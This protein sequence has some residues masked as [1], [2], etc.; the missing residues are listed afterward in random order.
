MNRKAL[1]WLLP[2]AMAALASP[3]AAETRYKLPPREVVDILD[4]PATPQIELSP[5]RDRALLVWFESH[6]PL[7]LLAQPVLR[8]AGLRITP[9]LGARQ[10][11]FRYTGIDVLTLDGG[12]TVSVAL[13]KGARI[14]YPTWS[15]DG[16]RF[17]FTRD[18][19]DRV[20]LWVADAA[21]GAAHVVQGVQ[22]NDVL[23]SPFAWMAD[24]T[25]LLVRA[26]PRGRAAAPQQPKVPAGP[27]VDETAGKTSQVATFQDLL[28]DEHDEALFEYYGRTQLLEVRAE[29]GA[30]RH[31]GSPGLITAA[32]VS[33]DGRA[34]LVTR[35]RR[36][37][38]FHVPYNSFTRSVEVWDWDGKRLATVADLPVSDEVPRQG[39]PTGPRAVAWQ[40]LAPATLVWAEALDGGDP[41]KK[42]PHRDR[43]MTLA[44]PFTGQPREL[45]K[46][47]HRY[48]SLEW[49]ARAGEAL[50]TEFDRDRRWRTTYLVDLGAATPAPRKVFDLS[51]RD[52]YN[53][54]G[55]PVTQRQPGG[56]Q[57]LLQDGDTIY[58][59]GEGATAEGNRPFVD[60]MDLKTLKKERLFQSDAGSDERFVGFVGDSRSRMLVR[61]ESPSEPPN[62]F[63]V[64]AKGGARQ[65]LTSFADPFPQLQSVKRELVKYNRA[66]GVPLSGTLYLPVGYQPGT[67]VPALVWA[68]P[69]EYSDAD[70]AGQVRSSPHSFLRLSG[71]SPLFLVTRG[72]AVLM[73]ATMPVVGDPE[74]VNN[75]Y[76]EQITENAKAAVAKLDQMGVVDPKRVLVG[77]HSYG[78]FMT[79]N[80]LAH[81]DVFLA[82]IARSGAYNR[83]L[84]PFGFQS[85]RRSFWE[86]PDVYMKMSPFSHAHKINEPVLFIHGEADNNSGTFPIQSERLFAAIRG[87]GGTAR[88]VMLPHESHGY[89]ARESVLHTLA[90]MIDWADR[91]AKPQ[92]GVADR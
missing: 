4:A 46:V 20:E 13:P 78:A 8:I 39:V 10:R 85:E 81:T 60:A 55:D 7:E 34:L 49:T 15:H 3:A 88:L 47:Q 43:L 63:L 73:D 82:G 62:F 83:T 51:S 2:A 86:A 11:T 61:R 89:R 14:G 76:V 26:V 25:R 44:A 37:F 74:T 41:L 92:G 30:A 59:A 80:L 42:A 91:W 50:V 16:K 71:T 64:E 72:Y 6:P 57:I 45:I 21:S 53:D 9:G 22:V 24:G 90:E 27:I 31:V 65:K 18:L 69:L 48:A 52:A 32:R 40:S 68:Y 1:P 67:R 5:R 84:T 19:A 33:P 77:G 75:T 12:R 36:P 35:L 54:P 66:D 17:A 38:S 28:Q 58:L 23:G 70:T 56:E 29:T 79:A 87:S